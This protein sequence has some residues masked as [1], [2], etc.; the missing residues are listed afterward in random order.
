MDP[1]LHYKMKADEPM[2]GLVKNTET[3]GGRSRTQKQTVVNVDRELR[4]GCAS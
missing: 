2:M 3:W 1:T 4:D